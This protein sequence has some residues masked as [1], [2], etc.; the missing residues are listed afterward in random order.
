MNFFKK[1]SFGEDEDLNPFE[2]VPDT[3]QLTVIT[4]KPIAPGAEEQKVNPRSRSAKLRVAQK[5]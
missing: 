5:K 3:N 1:G 2:N 4:K